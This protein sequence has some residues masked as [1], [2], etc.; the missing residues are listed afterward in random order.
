MMDVFPTITAL[1]GA[2]APP[3]P[4]DGIRQS[5]PSRAG[6]GGYRLRA[7]QAIGVSSGRR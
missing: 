1:A 5:K 3:K 6:A 7:A 2:P 4:L